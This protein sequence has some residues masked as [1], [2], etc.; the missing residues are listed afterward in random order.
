[1]AV[2]SQ[3]STERIGALMATLKR[4]KKFAAPKR[5]PVREPT[6]L[7]LA[8]FLREVSRGGPTA[9]E[10]GKL[11]KDK[12]PTDHFLVSP[13]KYLPASHTWSQAVE[14]QPWEIVNLVL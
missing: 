2:P 14:L 4:W 10:F 11:F 5:C 13:Y 8:E 12:L 3:L 7:Q 9:V 1:M 6:A